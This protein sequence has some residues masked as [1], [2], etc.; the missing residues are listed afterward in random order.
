MD[1]GGCVNLNGCKYEVSA[2][3]IG[4]VVEIAYDPLNID[5]ITVTYPGMEPITAKKM[6]IGAFASR[7][8]EIPASLLPE[9]PETSRMLDV[10]EKMHDESVARKA[11]AI[12][13][14]SYRKDGEK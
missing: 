3:L 12:S 4:A 8:P 6:V 14:G 11:D 13:F 7:K 9:E 5:S 2:A 1:K 10:L